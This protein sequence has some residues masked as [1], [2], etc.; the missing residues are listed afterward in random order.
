MK[1]L[2]KAALLLSVI[3]IL[4][5]VLGGTYSYITTGTPSIINTFLSGLEPTGDLVIHKSL[6]HPFGEGYQPPADLSFSFEADLGME[7]AGQT[8]GIYTADENGKIIFSLSDGVNR[9]IPDLPSGTQVTVTETGL[10]TG[11]APQEPQTIT[12]QRGENQIL[13]VNAYSP[14]PVPEVNLTVTGTK[15]L[16]GRDWQPWDSFTFELEYKLAGQENWTPV[17]STTVKYSVD[18]EGNLMEGFDTFDFTQL[19]QSVSYDTWGTYCFRIS[20]TEGSIGGVSYDP[21]VAYFD[22]L[23]GDREMDGYLE[24]Q[25]VTCADDTENVAPGYDDENALFTVDVT[26]QN[27]YAPAGTSYVDILIQKFMDSTSLEYPSPAGY[28]FRLLDEEGNLLTETPQT[29]EAGETMIRLTYGIEE[30]G[31]VYHYKLAETNG[32]EVIHHIAYDSREYD[33]WIAAVDNLD[34]TVG[35]YIFDHT[36]LEGETFGNEFTCCFTNIYDPEDTSITFTGTKY[37]TGRNMQEG[38]FWFDLYDT[39]SSFRIT[40]DMLPAQT[41]SIDENGNFTF[42]IEYSQIGTY[43]YVVKENMT[44]KLGGITYDDKAYNVLV[45][46]WDDEGCLTAEVSVTDE[47]NEN[48]NIVFQNSYSAAPA[49]VTLSGTKTLKNMDLKKDMFGFQLFKADSGFNAYGAAIDAVTNGEDGTFAFEEL[50]FDE[51]G[52]YYYVIAEDA[53]QPLECV[54]YDESTYGVKI[55]VADD[56]K[57]QLVAQVTFCK[58]GALAEAVIFENV[59]TPPVNPTE[60]SET[61]TPTETTAPTETTEPAETTAPTEPVETGEPAGTTAPSQT[62]EPTGTTVPGEPAGTTAPSE[63]NQTSQQTTPKTG[64]DSQVGLYVILLVISA[65]GLAVLLVLRKRKDS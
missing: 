54:D 1:Y 28:T 29:G 18:E 19:I 59:Y 30:I 41:V 2:K 46:V 27:A 39:G 49:S 36:P 61:T 24:I 3:L 47:D 25:K 53:S 43:R 26:F 58:D 12:I 22:V 55:T 37:L 9:T 50:K 20:E 51:T 31:N 33:L 6:T 65:L 63:A 48:A 16:E 23:V 62:T 40:D 8:F 17:G 14:A 52:E 44:A 7:N 60:P 5:C 10:T 13:F 32:G 42:T 34:G 56:L 21:A 45:R 38:E 35:A 15:L 57:G 64:D 4:A 11:F